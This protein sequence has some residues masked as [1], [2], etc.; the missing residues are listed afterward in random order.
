MTTLTQ[1]QINNIAKHR[2][3][4][5]RSLKRYQPIEPSK[6]IT[7][8]YVIAMRKLTRE[9]TDLVV[10]EVL[11]ILKEFENQY[12]P[13]TTD[14]DIGVELALAFSSIEQKLNGQA[15]KLDKYAKR[16]ARNSI[17]RGAKFQRAKWVS[18]INKL[19]GIDVRSILRDKNIEALLLEKIEEN[20]QLI[21]T[22]QPQY[23]EQVREAV[24]EGIRRGDDFFS[25]RERLNQLESTN[26]KYRPQ[27]IAR[28]Q[29]SKLTGDLNMFRQRDIG[30]REY[31]WRT[32]GDSA[33]RPSHKANNGKTF[34]WG[35]PPPQ[36]GHPGHDINCRCVAEPVFD[37]WL[38][39]VS[40][41][42]SWE[43]Q[44]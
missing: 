32:V 35:A 38:G 23:L 33:V 39:E 19:A 6:A 44:T 15:E 14:V 25:I 27:L 20:V 17:T 31:I 30:I 16:V 42:K 37:K 10:A 4:K 13:L 36:T 28:D 40:R 21:K 26:V 29:M 7:A 8:E 1:T 5:A 18:Q 2:A 41:Q 12:S 11:P 43:P 24:T 3:Q 34:S 22:L 9:V